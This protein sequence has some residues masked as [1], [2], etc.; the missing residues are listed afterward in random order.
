MATDSPMCGIKR[1]TDQGN[2]LK[3]TELIVWDEATMSHKRALEAVDRMLRDIRRNDAV[4]GGVTL[5][6]AGD[7]RQTL[8]IVP[9]GT[10]ANELE[11]S[12]KDSHLWAHIMTLNLKT[13]MRAHIFGDSNSE[14]FA[15]NLLR[16]GESKV[17]QIE[18][19][20]ILL[21]FGKI[22]N[23]PPELALRV[24]PNLENNYRKKD[25]FSERAILAPKNDKVSSINSS[26]LT[27]IPGDEQTFRSID[28][29]EEDI[30]VDNPVE[31]LKS[32]N[33]PGMPPHL[34][35]G[36]SVILLRNLNPPILCNGTRLIVERMM[37]RLYVACSRVGS[38]D[39]LHV[40]AK[41]GK[42]VNLVY[43]E[44]LL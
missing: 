30:A 29:V 6:L 4:M 17:K 10:K 44:A 42:T 11:A 37:P 31:F 34:K 22:T 26:L 38:H 27:T 12:I 20:Q 21:P 39:N 24:F 7:F 23:A 19:N 2:L 13:N 25:W 41:D 18:E 33:P 9:R 1:G 32:L 15:R 40:L 5:V 35:I 14:I 36:A 28:S 8:P 43:P 3:E 16:L